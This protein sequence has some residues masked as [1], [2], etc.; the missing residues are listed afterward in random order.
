[1]GREGRSLTKRLEGW[2]RLWVV[3]STLWVVV[4]LIISLVYFY[5]VLVERSY[6]TPWGGSL[7]FEVAGAAL[8]VFLP[9][10][11]VEP[12]VKI[13]FWVV[14]GFKEGGKSEGQKRY[15]IES[16]TELVEGERYI[17]SDEIHGAGGELYTLRVVSDFWNAHPK[18][19]KSILFLP[20]I[21][22]IFYGVSIFVM[23]NSSG[24]VHEI[25]RPLLM[26]I[27]ILPAFV[28]PGFGLSVLAY[29][30]YSVVKRELKLSSLLS[31]I[32]IS[33]SVFAFGVA[34]TIH[35]NLG[36]F[37]FDFIPYAFNEGIILNLA[38]EAFGV[39]A[40]FFAVLHLAVCAVREKKR[41]SSSFVSVI[42][43]WSVVGFIINGLYFVQI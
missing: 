11:L 14:D 37:D 21:T 35:E 1:M 13:F 2:K 42:I 33:L 39:S 41:N 6:Y 40:L 8:A 34:R 15:N 5:D 18:I 16:S 17:R 9:P 24:P 26:V 4:G 12:V 28:F 32:I 43:G 23:S 36:S 31:A 25:F 3:A 38:A 19:K 30:I 22:I 20:L 10:F 27:L 29:L 7:F